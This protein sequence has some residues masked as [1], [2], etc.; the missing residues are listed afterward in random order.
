MTVKNN[1]I[2]LYFFFYKHLLI[3]FSVVM[4][5]VF[6]A[7]V[8]DERHLE[9]KIKSRKRR[10]KENPQQHST[11]NMLRFTVRVL[12]GAVHEIVPCKKGLQCACFQRTADFDNITAHMFSEYHLCFSKKKEESL[13]RGRSSTKASK[14]VFSPHH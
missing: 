3:V 14:R 5:C 9:R 8:E 10:E 13:T 11:A 4:V 1:N 2:Q 6:T 7:S 12:P